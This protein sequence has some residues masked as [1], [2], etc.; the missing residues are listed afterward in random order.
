M[1]SN[2]ALKDERSERRATM[3]CCRV[4]SSTLLLCLSVA[5]LALRQPPLA[6]AQLQ[7]SNINISRA[8]EILEQRFRQV[9][10]EGL[11]VDM[12]LN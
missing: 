11:G 5:L 8:V 4:S 3:L 10:N 2:L 9:A 7:L 12:G 6:Q 1:W